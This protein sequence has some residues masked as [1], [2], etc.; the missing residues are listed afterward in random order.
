M[1]GPPD[2][3]SVVCL[4][5]L[6]PGAPLTSLAVS[7]SLSSFCF[8]PV[9]LSFCSSPLFSPPITFLPLSSLLLLS[10]CASLSL[11]L[12]SHICPSSPLLP[13]LCLC[14][15]Y[16][17]MCVSSYVHLSLPLPSICL[18]P[19]PESPMPPPC[20]FLLVLLLIDSCLINFHKALWYSN[21]FCLTEN[22]Y[23]L[24]L[25]E[26]Y[27]HGVCACMCVCLCSVFCSLSFSV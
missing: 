8:S 7:S 4:G 15:L 6:D 26:I 12:S 14:L 16:L 24:P 18:S 20:P 23:V 9:L 17:P 21:N 3:V 10:L 5:C 2:S 1:P 13:F 25:L 19:L 27:F 22:P 11:P